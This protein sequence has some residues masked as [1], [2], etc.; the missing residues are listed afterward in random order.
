VKGQLKSRSGDHSRREERFHG[1]VGVEGERTI[2]GVR[3]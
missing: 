1:R 3:W 2:V